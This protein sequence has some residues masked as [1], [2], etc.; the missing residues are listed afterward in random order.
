[1]QQQET[2]AETCNPAIHLSHQDAVTLEPEEL[3]DLFK[4]HNL[5]VEPDPSESVK[6]AALFTTKEGHLTFKN[7]MDENREVEV[8]VEVDHEQDVSRRCTLKTA[9]EHIYSSDGR[10]LNLLDLPS[11][12]GLFGKPLVISGHATFVVIVAGI[13]KIWLICHGPKDKSQNIH[14][15]SGPWIDSP[16]AHTGPKDIS[17]VPNYY[18]QAV[19]LP[20]G[21]TLIMQPNT[22]HPVLTLGPTLCH[23]G[24]FYSGHTLACTLH[25]KQLEH[26]YGDALSNKTQPASWCALH[27][28]TIYAWWKI[29]ILGQASPYPIDDLAAL[30]A[31]CLHTRFF[32]NHQEDLP[33]DADYQTQEEKAWMAAEELKDK[34]APVLPAVTTLEKQVV[35]WE[36]QLY[37][38]WNPELGIYETEVFPN[39]EGQV[40]VK[41]KRKESES[42]PEYEEEVHQ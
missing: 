38:W 34:Y 27:R 35:E 41:G 3:A 13:G 25:G 26:V 20:V 4:N 28:M 22:I 2:L 30:I 23:G 31:L 32:R 36:S 12:T 5:V 1:M 42:E 8:H 33:G 37:Q 21:S 15:S 29:I 10:V 18:W 7:V 11:K 6:E 39:K 40:D 17:W 14:K 19:F 16:W 9:F 24:H